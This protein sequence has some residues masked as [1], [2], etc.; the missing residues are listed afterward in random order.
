MDPLSQIFTL[1]VKWPLPTLEISIP[2]IL[3]RIFELFLKKGDINAERSDAALKLLGAVIKECAYADITQ[4]Q[5][6]TLIQ[7]LTPELEEPDEQSAA[8]ALI[9][10]ILNR[11][12]LFPEIYD[13]M[14]VVTKIMVTSQGSQVRELCRQSY[15]HFL[16][17]YPHGPVKLKKE[18]NYLIQ[19]LNYEFESGR[20]SVLSFFGLVISKLTDTVLGYDFALVRDGFDQRRE[21]KVPREGKRHD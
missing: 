10:S 21:C 1:L 2:A 11:K 6:I 4:K 14:A 17:E 16:L 8:F 5:I 20:E 13:L 18:F 19:N 7:F 15:T 9:R 3:K 12:Y